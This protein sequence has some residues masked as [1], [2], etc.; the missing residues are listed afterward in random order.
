MPAAS[1]TQLLRALGITVTDMRDRWGIWLVR[2][3]VEWDFQ[4]PAM[5]DEELDVVVS[6]VGIGRSSLELR[7]AIRRAGE[8]GSAVE[9]RYVLVAVERD[10]LRPVP[11]PGA[12]RRVLERA[13]VAA[14]A[15]EA[16]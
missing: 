15:S 8:G 1:E 2:R 5:L 12:V 16:R 14:E 3:R 11:L 4:R 13:A 6:I 9:A 7:F 10:T